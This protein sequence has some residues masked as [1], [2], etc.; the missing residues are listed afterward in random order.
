MSDDPSP[1]SAAAGSPE[2]RCP[3][4]DTV[5]A[6]EEPTCR[7]CGAPLPPSPSPSTPGPLPDA[8]P[9]LGPAPAAA[10]PDVVTSVVRERQSRLTWLI[11]AVIFAATAIVGAIVLQNPAP[12]TLAL[13]PTSTPIP[14]TTTHTPTWTPLPSPTFPPTAPPTATAPPQPLPT[15]RPPVQITVA[16]GDTLVGLAFRYQVSVDSIVLLNALNPDSPLIQA[17]RPLAIP[18]PTPTPPLQ[19]VQ[20]EVGGEQV[21][22]D[23]AGCERY[24]IQAN[25]TLVGVADRYDVPLAALLAVNRLNVQSLIRPGDTVCIPAI[26]FTSLEQFATP[27]PSPTPGPTEPPVGPSLLY[28][29]DGALMEPP[30]GPIVLQW[31]AVKDLAPDE[32]YM[33]ALRD[34]DDPDGRA[35]RGFTRQTSFAVPSSWRPVVPAPRRVQ[36]TISIV[37]VTGQRRDGAFIYTFGGRVSAPGLF[38]WPGA[39]PTPTPPPTPTPTPSLTPPPG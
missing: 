5:Q 10:L 29:P 32:W 21:V 12:V 2:R 9:D 11:T 1:A 16:A 38:V 8:A 26:V 14:P 39:V 30:E 19:P 23:P 37:R 31:V 7:I 20:L 22:A 13:V 3:G 36:W 34:A 27:G 35:R 25:D 17:N 28:P 4:C 33:V 18:W 15:M 6:A 24:E